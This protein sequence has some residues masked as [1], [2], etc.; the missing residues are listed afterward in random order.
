[1]SPA[2]LTDLRLLQFA[3]D[4]VV[5]LEDPSLLPHLSNLL[6]LYCRASNAKVNYTK[7]SIIPFGTPPA[8]PSPFSLVQTTILHLGFPFTRQG[9]QSAQQAWPPLIAKVKARASVLCRHHLSLKGKVLVIKSLLLSQVWH[10]AALIPPRSED[11]V[12]LD[13]ECWSF[14][15][16]PGKRAPINKEVCL[17][18]V[19]Q[20]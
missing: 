14:L 18:P 1:S 20:G 12:A 3:D 2:L 10:L 6:S 13:K 5:L 15:W 11:L 9:V 19:S 17:R 16:G 4:T 8:D 7:S